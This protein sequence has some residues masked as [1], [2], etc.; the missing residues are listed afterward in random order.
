MKTAYKSIMTI[1]LVSLLVSL[2]STSIVKAQGSPYSFTETWNYDGLHPEV[3]TG[4]SCTYIYYGVR[5]DEPLSVADQDLYADHHWKWNVSSGLSLY[6]S[7]WIIGTPPPGDSGTVSYSFSQSSGNVSVNATAHGYI[8]AQGDYTGWPHINN[9]SFTHRLDL[10]GG[11]GSYGNKV[12]AILE[13]ASAGI[14]GAPPEPG[15]FGGASGVLLGMKCGFVI[16]TLI[17]RNPDTYSAEYKYNDIGLMT[18]MGSVGGY[19]WWDYCPAFASGEYRLVDLWNSIYGYNYSTTPP[20][21]IGQKYVS[22]VGVGGMYIWTWTS[23]TLASSESAQDSSSSIGMNIGKITVEEIHAPVVSTSPASDVTKSSATL[24]GILT[25]DGGE[26][27]QYRFRYK[28][29]KGDYVYSSW[30]GSVNSGQSFSEAISGLKHNKTYYFNA[31]ARNSAGES[32]LGN[33]QSFVTHKAKEFMITFDDGPIPDSGP[34]PEHTH[35]ILLQLMHCKVDGEPVKAAF[36]VVGDGDFSYCFW[37]DREPKGSVLKNPELVQTIDDLGHFVGNHTQHHAWFPRYKEFKYDSM[38]DFVKDEISQCNTTIE[39]VLGRAPPAIFRAPYLQQEDYPSA[40]YG[41]AGQ[42]GFTVVGGK[43]VDSTA[44][45][46]KR[47]QAEAREILENWEEDEPVVLI[48]H[49]SRSVT[50]DHIYEIITYLQN[51]RYRLVHFDPE[52]I[53]KQTMRD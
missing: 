45:N 5:Y 1:V 27:C 33:E 32:D 46:V 43:I 29:E 15:G 52:R 49:D 16:K 2:M 50:H 47:A 40:V 48:F 44:P 20:T 12:K 41:A 6:G 34:I 17:S 14:S 19:W 11:C 31:Q 7:A 22:N 21:E 24:N 38:E 9:A 36:F 35:S 10:V 13:N 26:A 51:E 30:Y 23:V 18:K 39:E 42:L 4:A 37:P 3:N 53:P 28:E 25:D 8:V